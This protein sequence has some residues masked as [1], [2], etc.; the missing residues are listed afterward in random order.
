MPCM[1][2]LVWASAG[3]FF[4]RFILALPCRR[5]QVRV[6]KLPRKPGHRHI[7]KNLGYHSQAPVAPAA[8]LSLTGKVMKRIMGA[9]VLVV[10]VSGCQTTGS[11]ISGLVPGIK[12]DQ[13]VATLGKPD[14][15]ST[16]GNVEV[17]TYRHRVTHDPLHRLDY[18]LVFEHGRLVAFGPGEA[19]QRE[20]DGWVIVPPA[21]GVR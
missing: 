21:H 12:P 16:E 18:A 14:V 4:K 10:A 20:P 5:C 1:D 13:V 2:M 7:C 11:K 19:K 15:D 8:G 3:T 9:I 6:A 17:Y